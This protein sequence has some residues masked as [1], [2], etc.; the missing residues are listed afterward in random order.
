YQ[1]R[2][3]QVDILKNIGFYTLSD[4][5]A[6]T[7]SLKS[8]LMRTE[9][10]LTNKCNFK[11]G[12]CR[13]LRKEIDSELPFKKA[14]EVVNYWLSEDLKNIRF[15][16]GE[17]TLYPGLVEL[18]KK[19]KAS[20]V[21]HIAV[22]SNGS[23]TWDTY[24]ELIKAGVNDFSISLDS[25]CA[26]VGDKMAGGITGAWE[27]VT[28]NIKKI[29]RKVYTT[30]GIVINEENL[31]TCANTV[32][33]ADKL[34]VSDIRVI[35]SAQYNRMLKSMEEIPYK[36]IKKYPILEYRYRNLR[37]GHPVRGLQKRDSHRCWLMIDDMAVAGNYHFP[38]IIYMREKGDP[39]GE[40]GPNMRYE[41]LKWILK[42]NTFDDKICRENCLDVCIDHNNRVRDFCVNR[43][44]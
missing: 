6:A 35:P 19:C 12:Y 28:S 8:P 39:V 14:E 4:K 16:G 41:R 31:S 10:I 5:R 17:P 21:E 34:G 33:L 3:K 30:V 11:C 9:L 43:L 18:V 23:A 40:V 37:G 42:H 22:S 20:G 25:C 36:L 2:I 32:K 7:A 44:P 1:E 38:C 24:R 27:T 13:G 26:S 15:S 29:S